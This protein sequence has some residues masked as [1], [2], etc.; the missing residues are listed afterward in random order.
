MKV[1]L[2]IVLYHPEL[3]QLKKS[4]AS[5]LCGPYELAIV[6]NSPQ[7]LSAAL[8]DNVKYIHFPDNVG[9]AKAQNAGI[10]CLLDKDCTHVAL[11]DQDSEI[12]TE[13]L[14]GLVTGF[15]Q[16][17]KQFGAVAAVGPQI[18]CE[19]NNQPVRPKVQRE[20]QIAGGTALVSQIIASGMLLSAQ[21]FVSVGGKE[22]ALFIDGV[23]HEWCWRA[24]SKGFHIVKLLNVFM[25]HRQGDGRERICG[26]TFKQGAPVR[27][28]Y[29]A[30]NILLL[31]RRRYVPLY[32]KL[33]NIPALPLRWLVNRFVF[34]Q[35]VCRG[36]NLIYACSVLAMRVMPAR[37]VKLAY[38]M[39]RKMLEHSNKS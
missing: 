5:L 39:D 29:Q 8:P 12:T 30:R 21:S 10:Q 22:E 31:S 14:N 13:L 7:R 37:V 35:G 16:A 25:V 28:Y 27:L 33:R 15:G 34:E 20:L 11:F 17:C 9:I 26:V 4:L 6:D 32:W 19:F 2:V 23:D 36:N 38:K 24:R 18:I 1:G 3:E